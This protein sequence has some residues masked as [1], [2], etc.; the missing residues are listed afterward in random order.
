MS[1]ETEQKVVDIQSKRWESRPHHSINEV[2]FGPGERIVAAKVGVYEKI[3]PVEIQ[4]LIYR[5]Q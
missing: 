1:S 4:F 2:N 3:W 5:Q